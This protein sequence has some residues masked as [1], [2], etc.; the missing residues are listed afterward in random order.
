MGTE[1]GRTDRER[2]VAIRLSQ[3]CWV[4]LPVRWPFRSPRSQ[5]FVVQT[6]PVTAPASVWLAC[7]QPR[8]L[9]GPKSFVTL[10]GSRQRSP[11]PTTEALP[12]LRIS[13]ASTSAT[14]TAWFIVATPVLLHSSGIAKL[15]CITHTTGRVFLKRSF[16][17]K[18][19]PTFPLAHSETKGYHSL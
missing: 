13:S 4:C 7:W 3:P 1:K 17:S 18:P 16:T 5:A 10:C 8:Q 19:P 9:L 15:W 11:R 2:S 6:Q 12:H 14:T